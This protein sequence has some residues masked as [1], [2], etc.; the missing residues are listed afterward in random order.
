MSDNRLLAALSPADR[1]LLDDHLHPV[2]LERGQTLFD[3]GEDVVDVHFPEGATITALVLTMRDGAA[4]EAA[5]I[6]KEGAIGGIVSVGEKPAFSRGVVQM[7]GPARRMSTADLEAVKSRSWTLRD[8]FDRYADCLL[9]QVM[10]SAACNA[11][12]DVEPRLARWLLAAHDRTGLDEMAMTH[13]FIAE[14][15][16]VQRTY[17][18]R[19]VGQITERGAIGNGR[20]VVRIVDRAALEA[21][22][23]EC[24]GR[25]RR[26]FDR[27]LPG[28]MPVV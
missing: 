9:A 22:S 28:V 3:P 16:G 12:H 7:R 4:A 10:Q 19:I 5:M 20:G 11:I 18:T 17:V 2:M 27:I 25:L 8:R 26:H 1:Q 13:D 24:Y 15:L 23:C 21:Q 6:G 14:M